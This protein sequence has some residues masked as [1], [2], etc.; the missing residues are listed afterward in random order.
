MLPQLKR[1]LFRCF[2]H[3]VNLAVQAILAELKS[4]PRAPVIVA[5]CN[6]SDHGDQLPLALQNYASAL[7]HDP[8]GEC[9]DIVSACRSSGQRRNRLR[10]VIEEG[11]KN[12]YWRGKL[13]DG[14]MVLP[15]VQLLR[16]CPTRWSSTFKMVDR[17]LLLNPVCTHINSIMVHAANS[18]WP[19][20]ILLEHGFPERSAQA[21][22]KRHVPKGKRRRYG[23]RT[24]GAWLQL[25]RCAPYTECP[26]ISEG[27]GRS[28]QRGAIQ[29]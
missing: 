19:K 4:N 14:K 7:E 8:V 21:E 23:R 15:V 17:V 6:S 9:R 12:N 1:S 24:D 3:V 11:N 13:P 22:R 28:R 26:F 16:D 10:N 29:R 18:D 2:P 25:V 27:G 20:A 5:S